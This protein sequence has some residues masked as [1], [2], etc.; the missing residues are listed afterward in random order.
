MNSMSGHQG[1][2]PRNA[3]LAVILVAIPIRVSAAV[4]LFEIDPVSSTLNLQAT[5][6]DVAW[7]VQGPGSLSATCHGWLAVDIGPTGLQLIVGSR[8]AVDQANSWQPGGQG[9][10]TPEPANY[11]GKVVIGTGFS[12][13]HEIAAL[14]N[15]AFDITSD[16]LPTDNGQFDASGLALA[17]PPTSN[18]TVDYRDNGLLVLSG[19][20]ALGGLGG[21]NAAGAAR[22]SFFAEVQ[23]LAIPINLSLPTQEIAAGEANFRFT[24]SIVARRGIM[25]L[26]PQLIWIPSP[27]TPSQVT[28]VWSSPYKLQRASTLNPPD[29]SDFAAAAP[30]D[31]PL[32]GDTGFFRVIA[33]E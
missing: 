18:A 31:I 24:G 10:S 23:T 17:I 28:L 4:E 16:L 14:R 1:I 22:L 3:A 2:R 27:T 7:Q 15:L 29:W 25:I 33:G 19:H 30:V 26:K 5:T 8:L 13:V 9:T 6:A 20:R 32:D 21:S 12:T 11:G